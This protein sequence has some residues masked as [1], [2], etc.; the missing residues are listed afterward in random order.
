MG[1]AKAQT[2]DSP[3]DTLVLFFL[4]TLDKA[5]EIALDENPTMKVAADEIALKKVA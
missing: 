5:I 4:L 3:Q 1:L 2:A